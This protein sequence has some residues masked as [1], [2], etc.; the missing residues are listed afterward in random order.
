[1]IDKRKPKTPKPPSAAFEITPPDNTG[2][3]SGECRVDQFTQ[4]GQPALEINVSLKVTTAPRAAEGAEMLC[5]LAEGVEALAA[6]TWSTPAP[7]KQKRK[8]AARDLPKTN[9]LFAPKAGRRKQPP[10]GRSMAELA[11]DVRGGDA[12]KRKPGRPPK[13]QTVCEA[14][15]TGARKRGIDLNKPPGLAQPKR[16][17]GRPVGSKT[18]SR[19]T[20]SAKAS[21]PGALQSVV[22]HACGRSKRKPGRPSLTDSAKAGQERG[23]EQV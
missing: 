22:D 1:M 18:K 15:V 14:I 4:Q 2:Y 10:L 9:E 23:A 7:A 20:E 12:P 5:R 8:P 21:E 19:K 11:G 3:A 13:S 16:K 6:M 17:R